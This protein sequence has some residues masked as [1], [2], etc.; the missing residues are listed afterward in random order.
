MDPRN[1][2][3][4]S[5]LYKRLREQLKQKMYSKMMTLNSL[6]DLWMTVIQ[7]WG[8]KLIL[9]VLLWSNVCSNTYKVSCFELDKLVELARQDPRVYGSRMTGA[10]FG[11]CTVTLLEEGAVESAI[12][13]IKV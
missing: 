3:V 2:N 11:G 7:H 9:C 8:M 10:G 4:H 6:V 1:T 13:R 12:Q 5:M